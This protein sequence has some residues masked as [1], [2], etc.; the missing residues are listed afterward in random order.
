MGIAKRDGN[1]GNRVKNNNKNSSSSGLL[2]PL[3]GSIMDDEDKKKGPGIRIGLSSGA[4]F[5][6]NDIKGNQN[7]WG[8]GIIILAR[9]VMDI[10]DNM[11]ILISENMADSLIALR[12]EYRAII[13]AIGE[14]SIKHSQTIKL[15]SAY[16]DEFGNPS[17]P[18][19]LLR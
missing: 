3:H 18:A 14:Y 17:L 15:Y 11:H 10:G 6:V 13:K 9:R 19:K 4:V 8:P 1:D 5:I 16:S 12:D 7:V 2:P